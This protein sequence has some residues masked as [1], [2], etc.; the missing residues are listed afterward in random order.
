M[1]GARCIGRRAARRGA[2]VVAGLGF[3]SRRVPLPPMS[4]ASNKA[5]EP[6][7]YGAPWILILVLLAVT[8]TSYIDRIAISVLAPTL[9]DEF[10]LSNSEYALVI[11]AFMVT[12]MIMYSVGGRLADL[13]GFRR[14]L[15]LYI[16]WWSV[17]GAPVSYTHLTLPTIYSV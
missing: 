17:S 12:Y 13:L 6:A 10:G 11:N 16:V 1:I 2:P 15:S 9:R 14:A 7:G 5:R 4:R 8:S 3:R